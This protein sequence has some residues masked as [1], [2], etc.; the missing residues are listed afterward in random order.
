MECFI[1]L[2]KNNH[3]SINK[4]LVMIFII[5]LLIS[6]IVTMFN[7]NLNDF[8][9]NLLRLIVLFY[10]IFSIFIHFK[11]RVQGIDKWD[12]YFYKIIIIDTIFL[13]LLIFLNKYFLV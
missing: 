9:R 6:F 2:T 1:K 11:Y 12:G 13:C 4:V 10:F 3:M 5:S 8:L 7:F